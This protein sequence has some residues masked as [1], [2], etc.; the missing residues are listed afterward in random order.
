MV[1]A[2][3]R[4]LQDE[5]ASGATLSAGFEFSDVLLLDWLP[6]QVRDPLAKGEV[7]E[8]IDSYLSKGRICEIANLNS[9]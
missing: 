7:E 4:F 9:A 2:A 1:F 5:D 6:T 8:E 3:S